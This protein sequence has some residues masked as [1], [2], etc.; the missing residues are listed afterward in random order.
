LA[1]AANIDF[2]QSAVFFLLIENPQIFDE[3]VKNTF[4]TRKTAALPGGSKR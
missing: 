3:S 1:G 4:L 2:Q